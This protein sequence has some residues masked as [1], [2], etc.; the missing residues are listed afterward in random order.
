MEKIEGI[1]IKQ[2]PFQEEEKIISIF[3]KENGIVQ[4][5]CKKISPKNLQTLNLTSLLCLGEFHLSGKPHT[6][7]RF[8]DGSILNLHLPLREDINKFSCSMQ[9]LRLIATTQLVDKPSPLLYQLLKV[10]LKNLC[11][12]EYSPVFLL[13]FTL[14]LLKYEGLI[15]PLSS[16]IDCDSSFISYFH[17]GACFCK[18]CTPSDAALW[19]KEDWDLV[20]KS[21]NIKDFDEL[22]AIKTDKN[23]INDVLSK[24]NYFN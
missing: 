21:L 19:E 17:E 9:M 6:L 22:Q 4:C 10:Y 18:D 11:L 20:I 2:I 3:S 7:K 8:V 16:C 15:S 23:K 24:L 12:L 13:S 1:V 5:I 14:K